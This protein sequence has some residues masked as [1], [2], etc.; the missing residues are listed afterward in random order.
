MAEADDSVIG[1]WL[2]ATEEIVLVSKVYR[3]VPG[4]TQIYLKWVSRTDSTE[5]KLPKR[6]ADHSQGLCINGAETSGFV[7]RMIV[8]K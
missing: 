4:H 3:L 6:E 7:L 2:A 1:A 5:I 8:S